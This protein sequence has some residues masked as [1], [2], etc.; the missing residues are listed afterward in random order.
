MDRLPRNPVHDAL[1]RPRE[2]RTVKTRARAVKSRM[3]NA[4]AKLR[5]MREGVKLAKA[6]S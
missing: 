2:L 3:D 1:Y 5:R 4:R 6:D